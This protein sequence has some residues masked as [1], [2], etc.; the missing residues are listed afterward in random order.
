AGDDLGAVR[1][2][3][4]L[5]EDAPRR[6]DRARAHYEIAR[7]AERTGRLL[8]AV[9]IYRRLVLTYPDLMPGERALSHLERLFEARG[10]RGQ[11]AHL[12][13]TRAI[14]PRL[15][16]TTLGDNLVYYPARVA[17]RR[18]L[19]T[20]DAAAAE[21]AERLYVQIDADHP[22]SGLW[23]DA[24]WQRSLL[25]HQQGRY[26][27]EIGAIRRLQRTF[28]KVS[29]FGHDQHAY[30]RLGQLR[31]ARLERV[32]LADPRAAA[33]SLA[34]FVDVY[35]DSLLRDDALYW[36][37]C[38]LLAAGEGVRAEA[39][40][41]RLAQEYPESKY[42]AWRDLARSDPQSPRCIPPDVAAE[43]GAP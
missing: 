30:F 39:T 18:F 19:A 8:D 7:L 17:H 16:H 25:Y 10:E 42:L 43:E 34:R 41:D 20:G 26:A 37:A 2:W 21:L 38:A 9:R 12:A 24:W 31:I 1:V 5:G 23:N 29:L 35:R 11:A 32:E 15:R 27:D 28:E 22:G 36:W 6:A 13:W 3:G 33:E 40:F 14:Y 4:H